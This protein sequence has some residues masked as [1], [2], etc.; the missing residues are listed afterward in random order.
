MWTSTGLKPDAFAV[1][2]LSQWAHSPPETPNIVES[3]SV[4][5][6]DAV[7]IALCR[8][9]DATKPRSAVVSRI[10]GGLNPRC[11]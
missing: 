2:V 7:R 11:A 10:P 1:A 3:W 5:L 6:L 9:K 8:G 4:E